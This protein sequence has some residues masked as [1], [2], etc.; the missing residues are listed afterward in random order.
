MTGI[1][2]KTSAEMAK[3]LGAFPG[4]ERN[5]SD[6]LRVIKNHSN[7]AHGQITGYEKLPIKPVAL[8]IGNCKVK[9]LAKLASTAWNSALELGMN[10]GFRNA[11]VSVIAPTGTIGLIM[12]CDT[13]GIEPDFA[14][15][16]FKKL[17]GGGYFKIIN[18]SVPAALSV[19]GYSSKQTEQIISFAVGHGTLQNASHINHSS[20]IGHGFGKAELEK[21]ETALPS[22][23]DIRYVFNQW[24][25]G[26]A[27]CK[28]TLGIPE[29]KLSDPS[30]NL[31][32]HLGF[33]TSEIDSANI[34][35]CG[36]MTVEGAP[37]LKEEHY[38]VFDC[39]NPCGKTGTRFLS[40]ES[41]IHMMAAAQSFISGAISKTI[42]MPANASIEDCKQAYELSWSLGVKANALYRDG[43]KLSQ[44]LSAALIDE[45]SVPDE[46]NHNNKVTM[47]AEK[48]VE[49]I[50]I[51][52]ATKERNKLPERRKGYT[53]KAIVGGHKVYL[54]TGEYSDGNLGEIFIDMH[55][56]GAAF[57]AMM[58]N[59]AIAVSVGLQYGVPLE[60]FVE[61]FTFTR[62]E[63]AGIV[64]GND[65]IKSATS[66]IDY[67]FREL[68]ISY[69]DRTDLAHVKPLG[70]V[71]DELG[72]DKSGVV[73]LNESK[74]STSSVKGSE[75]NLEIIKKLSST[76]YL[77][78]RLPKELTSNPTNSD[79]LTSGKADSVLKEQAD[80]TISESP[81]K[82][83]DLG[84]QD[85]EDQR[86]LAKLQGYEGDA[87][88][89]CGSFTLVRNGTCLKCN[90]C[91]STT[92]CS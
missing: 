75:E 9:G 16:K 52:E 1:A 4:Y 91:G 23:F 13:T 78:K 36:T 92:G 34:H 18:Q 85:K 57:R 14:L 50:I 10:S 76:G 68:A 58:N 32:L 8:D 22:C 54:R 88:S 6:M 12:D 90:N 82:A 21:I 55:K 89:E 60:E 17:A 67:I 38:A 70:E 59:F 43:S 73:S 77:R 19:L 48:I 64:Q 44:P 74:K 49:K 42:N 72:D 33:K 35:A 87:C 81:T 2:Y 40:V 24:T 7:A 63:P 28:Q 29:E 25:L 62:F 26:E 37:G 11:Q 41:H 65:S 15:V 80:E 46:V 56:E 53:Q 86:K 31:L 79:L 61:A 27:F 51:R 66:I 71:F 30:F 20:L 3:E 84:Y 5:K 47:V 83:M 69:L 45:E 39:A